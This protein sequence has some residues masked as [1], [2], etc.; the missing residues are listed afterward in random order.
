M[1]RNIRFSYQ[2]NQY[3]GECLPCTSAVF[4]Q[5]VDSPEVAWKIKM[6]RAVEQAITEAR[7][8]DEFVQSADFRKF[9]QKK[10]SKEKT[11][12]SF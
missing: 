9:C 10:E 1:E 6:R 5:L 11:A 4:N 3:F 12:S 8:L 7:P 2:K